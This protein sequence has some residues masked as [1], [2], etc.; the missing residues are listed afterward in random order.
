MPLVW[1]F[2]SRTS[3]FEAHAAQDGEGRAADVDGLAAAAQLRGAFD[4][5]G[6]EAL[7]AQPVGEGGAGDAGA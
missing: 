2:S 6:G 3:V 5:D 7:L 4:D 1:F